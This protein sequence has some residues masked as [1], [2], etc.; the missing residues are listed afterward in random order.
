M[1]CEKC[2]YKNVQKA[3][4]CENCGAPF[5]R[6]E[7]EGLEEKQGISSGIEA[8]KEGNYHWMY[9]FS[10]W[11][12]PAVFLTSFKVLLIALAVPSLLMFFLTLGEDGLGAAMQV[13]ISMLGWGLILVVIL[14]LA[15]YVL[16][17][18]LYGGKYYVLFKMDKRGIHHIQLDKQQKKAQALG[19]LTTLM[20]IASGSL[21][22]TGAGI[23]SASKKSSY[24]DFK[25]V[26]SIVFYPKRNT[27]YLNE[28]MNKNQIYAEK[29]DYE[30]VKVFILE[31]CSKKV[32][33]REK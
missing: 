23:L 6:E 12:N 28:S 20:G 18:L 17:S 5:V 1:F 21:A 27:I 11:K 16:I 30:F 13:L 31:N 22:A 32:R 33:V 19:L 10:L 3:A 15:A 4:F 29:E 2:G 26:K 8:N 14:L 7:A 25:K 24:T 9:E